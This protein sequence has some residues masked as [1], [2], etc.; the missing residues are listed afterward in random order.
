MTVPYD[1]G[2]VSRLLRAM[3]AERLNAITPTDFQRW[4]AQVVLKAGLLA[5]MIRNEKQRR[6]PCQSR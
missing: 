2:C 5:E 4:P 3:P 1:R 6:A